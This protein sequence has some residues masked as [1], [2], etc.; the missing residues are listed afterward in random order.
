MNVLQK[1]LN[2]ATIRAVLAGGL[3][4]FVG[5]MVAE[6]LFGRPSVAETFPVGLLVG[7]AIGGLLGVAEGAVIRAWTLARRGLLIGLGVGAVGGLVGA[8]FAQAGF[9]IAAATTSTSQQ[10]ASSSVFSVEMQQRL[11]DAGAKPGEIEIALLWHNTNDLDLHVTDPFGETIYY[12]NKRSRS[13]GELDVDRNAGCND[14]TATPVEHVVWPEGQAPLGTY[15]VYVHHY[16]NCG[17]PDPTA[18]NVE[19][20]VDGQRQTFDGTLTY[21]PR[22][23]RQHVHTFT[24][25]QDET[26]AATASSFGLFAFLAR[27]LGWAVFGALVGCAEGLTRRSAQALRNAALGGIVGGAVGG[28]AFEIIARIL[29]PM[30]FS[31]LL[32]RL[33]GFVIL[34][35]C[36][37]FWIVL[38]ERALSAVLTIRSG[39]Y[40]GREI[41]LDRPEMRLGRNDAQEIF[42]GGDAAIA[43]HHATI[44][45]DGQG[46]L[47]VPAEG[48]VQ[49]NGSAVAGNCRLHH[50]DT[51]LIGGTR[52]V[53]R[54]KAAAQPSPGA[55]APPGTQT[56]SS[57]SAPRTAPPPPP[58]P[59]P[60]RSAAGPAPGSAP[61][62]P[63]I[64]PPGP[65]T[66]KPPPPPRT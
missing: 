21:N 63:S 53:Y 29:M 57:G 20:I 31:D 2:D 42:L 38:I 66:R 36:I 30:G 5:W 56:A 39:R 3:G 49:V 13:G 58:P 10:A 22:G 32:S 19:I 64:A 50:G 33:L 65:S 11:E 1:G 34:G 28:L 44:R 4:G 25:Q 18:Y 43:F 6:T 17:A 55:S 37:G 45:R 24:R 12:R 23:A 26:Q 9:S 60:R 27:I 40:E 47:L 59:P 51:L 15:V 62:P 48:P 7:A 61:T 54:H 52:L 16:S 8:A 46:H 14:L 35:A 41:L